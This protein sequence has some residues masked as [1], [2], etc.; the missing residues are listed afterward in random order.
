MSIDDEQDDVQGLNGLTPEWKRRGV[1][2]CVRVGVGV[3]DDYDDDDGD[4]VVV[5]VVVLLG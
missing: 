1:L 2:D 5:V 3:V 4:V